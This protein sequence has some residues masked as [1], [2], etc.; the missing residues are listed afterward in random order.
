MERAAYNEVGVSLPGSFCIVQRKSYY[1]FA[2]GVKE[3]MCG[4]LILRHLLYG[5]VI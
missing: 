2:D 1:N 5:T 3:D 4:I